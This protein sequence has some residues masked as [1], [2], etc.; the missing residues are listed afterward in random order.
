MTRQELLEARLERWARWRSDANRAPT[1]GYPNPLAGLVG[2]GKEVERSSRAVRSSMNTMRQIR[3]SLQDR[4][5]AA[6]EI[7]KAA[8][9][10]E[11]DPTAA[12]EVLD[13]LKRLLSK[14]PTTPTALPWASLIHGTGPRPDPDCPEEEETELAVAALMPTLRRVVHVEYRV[15]LPQPVKAKEMGYSLATYKRRLS[16]ARQELLYRLDV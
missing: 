2:E 9:E 6:K 3:S 5:K 4:I 16:E 7:L 15:H 13:N 12:Q 10:A 11:E 14:Y 8:E 1:G